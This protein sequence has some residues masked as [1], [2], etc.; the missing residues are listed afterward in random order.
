MYDWMR[1]VGQGLAMLILLGFWVYFMKQ[2]RGKGKG[3]WFN[4]YQRHNEL[5]E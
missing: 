3:G 4:P 2:M 5:L 1:W